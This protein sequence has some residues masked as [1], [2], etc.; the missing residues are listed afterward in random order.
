MKINLLIQRHDPDSPEASEHQSYTV[1]AD[2][3]DRVLDALLQI[4]RN[5]ASLHPNIPEKGKL[6]RP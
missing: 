3:T 2:P 4:Q 5:A 6:K 1:E